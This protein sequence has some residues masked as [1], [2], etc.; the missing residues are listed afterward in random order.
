M[1][2]YFK[3]FTKNLKLAGILASSVVLLTF[4][5]PYSLVITLKSIKMGGI[6]DMN[7]TY[8]GIIFGM[9]V[10]GLLWGIILYKM[11]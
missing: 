9:L 10:I 6:I 3:L 1:F 11:R 2:I 7:V 4:V 8:A 5:L